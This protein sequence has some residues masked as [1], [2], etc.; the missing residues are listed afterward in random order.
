MDGARKNKERNLGLE[1]YTVIILAAGLGKRLAP[2]TH[3]LPKPACPLHGE[4]I[5]VSMIKQ[6]VAAGAKT[7]HINT[8]YLAAN[9]EAEVRA[10]FAEMNPKILP[11]LRFWHEPTRLE[12]GGAIVRIWQ[13]LGKPKV[14]GIF[15]ISGDIIGKVPTAELLGAWDNRCKKTHAAMAVKRLTETRPD[16]TWVDSNNQLV[17]GFGRIKQDTAFPKDSPPDQA[18]F[19]NFQIIAPEALENVSLTHASSTVSYTHLT[20]P[21]KA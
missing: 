4:P 21:T 1:D 18:L 5:C 17:V 9:L 7:V 15:V 10:Y 16:V 14:K 8:S 20:L 2:L 13:E 11:R 6:V 19:A 12:T 3:F